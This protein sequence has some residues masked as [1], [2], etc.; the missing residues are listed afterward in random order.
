MNQD[1]YLD[2]VLIE[3]ADIGYTQIPLTEWPAIP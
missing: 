3:R 2:G 1:T